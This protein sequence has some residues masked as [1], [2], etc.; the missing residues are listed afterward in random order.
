MVNSSLPRLIQ[1]T[2]LAGNIPKQRDGYCRGKGQRKSG[3]FHRA[4]PPVPLCGQAVGF[5]MAQTANARAMKSSLQKL[6]L[7]LPFVKRAGFPMNGR[8]CFN[9]CS[10][11]QWLQP[12]GLAD[13]YYTAPAQRPERSPCFLLAHA[14]HCISPKY[15]T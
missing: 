4:S 10:N 8:P 3:V 9:Y 15:C 2:S 1:I 13:T 6:R 11:I 7:V 12:E 14:S 5:S